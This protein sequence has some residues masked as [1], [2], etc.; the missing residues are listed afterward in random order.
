MLAQAQGILFS[1]LLPD[2]FQ[3][4]LVIP[5]MVSIIVHP[6]RATHRGARPR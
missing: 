1:E 6:P 5:L 4:G 2:S 3:R